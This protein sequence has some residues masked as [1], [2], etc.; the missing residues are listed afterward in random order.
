ML[1]PLTLNQKSELSKVESRI[2]CFLRKTSKTKEAK[3]INLK[4]LQQDI[5]RGVV[6]DQQSTTEINANYSTQ[7]R[8]QME[9]HPLRHFEQMQISAAA[10]AEF[11]HTEISQQSYA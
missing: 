4:R 6:E 11:P 10:N 8:K 2:S 7:D 3:T 9:S 1:R 5:A